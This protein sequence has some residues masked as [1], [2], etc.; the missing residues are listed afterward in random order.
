MLTAVKNPPPGEWKYTQRSTLPCVSLRATG[1]PPQPILHGG[2]H[3]CFLPADY[4]INSHNTP[5]KISVAPWLRVETNAA[6]TPW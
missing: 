6:V 5:I 3:D 2:Q 4:R 1:H